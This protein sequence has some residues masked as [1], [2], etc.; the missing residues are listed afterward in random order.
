VTISYADGGTYTRV[1]LRSPQNWWPVEQDYLLDDYVFRMETIDAPKEPL[2]LRFDLK[3]GQMRILTREKLI[4]KGGPIHGGSA[5]VLHVAIEPTR[6]LQEVQC[7][8]TLN[9]V[10]MGVLAISLGR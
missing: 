4:G 7:E 6:L 5:T 3:T 8:C 10:V 9:G 1:E 2:P